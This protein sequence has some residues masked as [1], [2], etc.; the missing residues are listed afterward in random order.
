MC[1][2]NDA[3]GRMRQVVSLVFHS[4]TGVRANVVVMARLMVKTL[5]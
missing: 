5:G 2:A 1:S 3:L 4:S